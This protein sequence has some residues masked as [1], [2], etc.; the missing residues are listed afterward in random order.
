MASEAER[1]R[2]A[3]DFYGI[4]RPAQVAFRRRVVDA[5]C[6]EPDAVAAFAAV[7]ISNTMRPPVMVYDDVSAALA[8]MPEAD[9][10]AIEG[11]LFGEALTSPG[12]AAL[13]REALAR[14][15]ADR[16]D[17]S[18]LAGGILVVLESH[19]LLAREAA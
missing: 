17:D 18:Q 13:V 2:A 9:R 3:W 12:P 19:G 6:G 10:P 5:R 15:R 16:L 11:R 7:G 8:G 14:G 4:P 1:H